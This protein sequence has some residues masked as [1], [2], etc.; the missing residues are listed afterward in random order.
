[1]PEAT[2]DIEARAS[3][4]EEMGDYAARLD[5]IAT[6]QANLQG[7][8][9]QMEQVTNP[10]EQFVVERLNGLPNITGVEAATEQN[11]PNGSLHK[12]GGYTAAVFFSS[13]LVDQS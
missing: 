12:D 1:M 4:I 7:S 13:D 3:E 11:D 5:A 10:A 6:A 2:E 8:I 9:D